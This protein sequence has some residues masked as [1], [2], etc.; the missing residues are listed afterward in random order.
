MSDYD[1]AARYD[2]AQSALVAPRLASN[3]TVIPIWIDAHRFW[4][5][6]RD[7]SGRHLRV[8]DARTA[9]ELLTVSVAQLA[10]EIG[11]ALDATVDPDDVII[12]NPKFDL[13]TR[14]LRFEAF[15]TAY[16]FDLD[17]AELATAEKSDDLTWLASPD[18]GQALIVRDY[19]LWVRDLAEQK[20]RPLTV[21]GTIDNAYG[22]PP[23]AMRALADKQGGIR[24]D[25]LWS[26]DGKWALTL[27][28]DEREVPA[29]PVADYA[30]TEGV[31]PTI[32]SNQTSLPG[33]PKVTE[34][35]IIAIEVDTG[36]NVEARYPRLKA[37]RMNTTPFNANLVW[38]SADSRTAYFVEIERGESRAHVVAFDVATGATRIVFSEESDTYVEVSVIVYTPALIVPL[39][40]TNELIWYSERSGR[41]HLYLYDLVTGAMRHAITEGEWQVLDVL[42]VDARNRTVFFLAGDFHEDV[43]PYLSKPCSASIDGSD[44]TILSSEPGEHRVW[45]PGDM[46]LVTKKLEG[47]DSEAVS[48]ISP[49]GTY[50]IETVSDLDKLPT[51]YLR[52]KVGEEICV[53]EAATIDLPDG[54]TPPER[55]RCLAADGKTDTFG[56]LFKPLGFDPARTYPVID[57]IYGGPQA[58]N[59]PRGHFADGDV[60]GGSSYV[61][62]AHLS[63]LG[64]FV[65]ILDGRG[66]ALRERAFRTASYRA[67]HTASNLEDHIAAIRQLAESRPQMDLNRV[68]LTGFSGGGYMTAIGA[69]RFGDFFRV[70]VA[71]GGNYDQALFWHSWGERYHGEFAAAHYAE[72]AA[73]TYADGLVGKLLFIHGM[74]DGGCHPS[75]L[76]QLTQALIE[77]DKDFDTILMPRAGHEW[78]GYGLRRRWAYFAEH[79]IGEIPP[80][81]KSFT[82]PIDSLLARVKRNAARPEVAQ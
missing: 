61:E 67:A 43:S 44:I 68:G 51:T 48:G 4:Y 13:E 75:A 29:L 66:T 78:T 36:R 40:E 14:K 80:A 59:V 58:S 49:D 25:A 37:V 33:D 30:P 81:V 35:R 63:S 21:G 16:A 50:I 20:D 56:V 74:L 2:F 11:N 46:S 34:F 7:E 38:W 47:I 60:L 6:R 72:Q 57:Y 79:L 71:G 69:L 17:R 54:W 23:I 70:A 28:T 27:Q 24:P 9:A 1:W 65:L 45:R 53:L 41:G 82:L 39:P 42:R 18:G 10:K 62:G 32:R 19:N 52:T 22:L 31:R 26:P 76:F 12:G 5:E 3:G 15:G 64:A 77:A 8:F 55:V 73:K